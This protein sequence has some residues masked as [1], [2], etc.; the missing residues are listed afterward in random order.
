MTYQYYY[1]NSNVESKC[2]HDEGK[3]PFPDLVYNASKVDEHGR[4][5]SPQLANFPNLRFT[6]RVKLTRGNELIRTLEIVEAALADI[7]DSE[8]EPSDDLAWAEERA[9]EILP[10]V[11]RVLKKHGGKTSE[12]VP[13][14]EVTQETSPT[15]TPSK[16]HI[17]DWVDRL[18]EPGLFDREEIVRKIYH[19]GYR[20]A[21]L[22]YSNQWPAN[23]NTGICTKE[24]GDR[25][26]AVQVFDERR[27]TWNVTHWSLVNGR[28]WLHVPNWKPQTPELILS[29]A[30]EALKRIA[31]NIPPEERGGDLGTVARLLDLSKKLLSE[32][33]K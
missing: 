11:R 8:H 5:I 1:A 9:L 15:I 12:L 30:E 22:K 26:G 32:K 7:G 19:S 20:D 10:E 31:A 21:E 2:W 6:W 25:W 29:E 17:E 3:G 13:T 14:T 23:P 16:E 18:A 28:P 4:D 24:D 33:K 27:N